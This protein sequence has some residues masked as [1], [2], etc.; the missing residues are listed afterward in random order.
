MS[1]SRLPE[2]A[3]LDGIDVVDAHHHFWELGRF[4]YLWL[5]PD[6]GPGRF[7]DK[8]TLRRNY[9]PDAYLDDFGGVK[10][11]ASV[12]VQANCGARD[13]S[14]ET[15]WLQQLSDR[16][17]WPAAI[18][19]EADLLDPD[20]PE[21]IRRHLAYPAL[22][23][24]RTPVGWDG[25]GRWRIGRQSGAMADGRFRAALDLLKANGL[26]LEIVIVPEQFKELAI[27]AEAQPD[28]T[29]VVDHFA[30]LEPDQPGNAGAWMTGIASIADLPNIVMKLSGLWTV[31]KGW[32]SDVLH[33]FVNHA[34]NHLGAD[35]I[36]YGSNLPVESVNCPLECQL[37]R[38]GEIL[39][40]H[41]REVLRDVFGETARR[42]YRLATT[43]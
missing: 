25:A 40:G 13:P 28:L 2:A 26:C 8:A 29:I 43:G 31:D 4:P 19:A 7:G 18:V 15:R 9:L 32:S 14:R 11:S 6:S 27:L 10:L 3:F 24:V 35:R 39:T 38:L 22:R 16:A 20:A 36:M 5:A 42:V 34:L 41:P 12:H 23:G 33:P 30:T 1:G 21:L 17:G 37:A